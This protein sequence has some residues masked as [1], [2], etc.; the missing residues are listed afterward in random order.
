MKSAKHPNDCNH[1]KE[2]F[3]GKYIEIPEKA[4]DVYFYKND[5]GKWS[6]CLRYGNEGHYSTMTIEHH[7]N[8]ISTSRSPVH[9]RHKTVA[10]MFI[11]FANKNFK[12][13]T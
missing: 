5:D 13:L 4:Y 3:A 12:E 6:S 9:E 10:E 11:K 2:S 8:A 7:I 1:P